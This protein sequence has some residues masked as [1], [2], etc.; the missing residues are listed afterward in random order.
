MLVDIYRPAIIGI[1]VF[2]LGWVN[3]YRCCWRMGAL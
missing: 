1:H 3:A 2:I